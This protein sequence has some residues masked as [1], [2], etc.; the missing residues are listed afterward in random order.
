[1]ESSRPVSDLAVALDDDILRAKVGSIQGR[2]EDLQRRNSAVLRENLQLRVGN[3][4]SAAGGEIWDRESMVNEVEELHLLLSNAHKGINSLQMQQKGAILEVTKVS[5][6][7]GMLKYRLELGENTK[8][9]K[10][11]LL[12][13]A[14]S[15]RFDEHTA[16]NRTIHELRTECTATDHEICDFQQMNS[17]LCLQL[18]G[19]EQR[20]DPETLNI[21]HLYGKLGIATALL[22]KAGER[23]A[24]C[25]AF[26]ALHSPVS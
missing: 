16:L 13:E 21:A 24:A 15:K 14:I 11:G 19:L 10:S 25:Q 6:E 20:S 4:R 17:Q 22:E 18:Q 26:V 2:I 1:M 9:V 12:I 3:T 8:E 7:L 5:K 23:V